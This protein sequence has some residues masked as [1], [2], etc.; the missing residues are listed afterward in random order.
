MAPLVLKIKG[1][2]SFLPFSNLDSEEDLSKTWRVCTKVKDSLENGSRLENLSWRLWFRQHL[3]MDKPNATFRKLSRTTTRQLDCQ[4]SKLAPLKTTTRPA[5]RALAGTSSVKMETIDAPAQQQQQQQQQPSPSSSSTRVMLSTPNQ[6]SSQH[7]PPPAQQQIYTHQTL[8]TMPQHTAACLQDGNRA[9]MLNGSMMGT[10][11]FTNHQN[12][13]AMQQQQQEQQQQQQST[14]NFTL[15][16]FTSDQAS[17]QIVELEDIFGAFGSP[18]DFL[19]SNDTHTMAMDDSWDFGLPSPNDG[20][21]QPN[22]TTPSNPS[23]PSIPSPQQQQQQQQQQQHQQNQQQQQQT[24]PST[25]QPSQLQSTPQALQSSQPSSQQPSGQTMLAMD[26]SLVNRMTSSYHVR[27]GGI[28]MS[29]PSSPNMRP[30]AD[31]QVRLQRPSSS[32]SVSSADNNS[33]ALYVSGAVMPPPPTATLRNKLLN[34]VPMRSLGINQNL[35]SNQPIITPPLSVSSTSPSS[36][37]NGSSLQLG[38][39]LDDQYCMTMNDYADFAGHASSI[40]GSSAQHSPQPTLQAHHPHHHP[41]HFPASAPSTPPHTGQTTLDLGKLPTALAATSGD[42][43]SQS[44]PVCS[45]CGATSTPL[46][47]RSADDDLLC[48]ACG[49]YQ[50]LHNAPRPKTLKPHNARKEARDDEAAQLVCSN[51]STTTTPLW[52]RDDEGAPLCNACGLYLKLHHER[53]PL[54]M[55]TDII[56]KRQRYDSNANGRKV[57]KKMKT[58]QQASEPSSPELASPVLPYQAHPG[59]IYIN[60]QQLQ[61]SAATAPP[62]SLLPSSLPPHTSVDPATMRDTNQLMFQ[63]YPA[64]FTYQPSECE[65][66][67][68]TQPSQQPTKPSPPTETNLMDGV[69]PQ[70]F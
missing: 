54:S 48:N 49:L 14:N 61:A 50:K 63:S 28:S 19:S 35:V 69:M 20:Y 6:A 40:H 55:K 39:L 22:S 51:C 27:H 64:A 58:D 60:Q 12:T 36:C 68:S 24:M 66:A 17:D 1:N 11:A 43:S 56:K 9:A 21:Y 29:M 32:S 34:N 26:N 59:P 52:R 31:A 45:N 65:H 46:W 67:A 18:H 3:L 4:N 25:T 10:M 33:D 38:A 41:H 53:R 70:Y 23:N 44:Q 57:N 5:P 2:K 8:S 47:R 13:F 16:Q 62:P 42:Y 15:H 37:A 7:K 30:Q